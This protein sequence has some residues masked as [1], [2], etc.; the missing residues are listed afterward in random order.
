MAKKWVKEKSYHLYAG[1]IYLPVGYQQ[2]AKK[3]F[4]VNSDMATGFSLQ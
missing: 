4:S 3:T 2:M 1:G